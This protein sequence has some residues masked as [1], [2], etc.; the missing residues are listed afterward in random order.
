MNQSLF[1][2]APRLAVISVVGLLTI[3]PCA[4]ATTVLQNLRTVALSD[5]V[6]PGVPS[7]V[8][9]EQFGYPLVDAFGRT[10]FKGLLQQNT[11]G[12]TASTRGVFWS[13]AAI[14]DLRYVARQGNDVPGFNFKFNDIFSGDE[15]RVSPYRAKPLETLTISKT[16]AE[17][18]FL[19]L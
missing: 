4:Q 16:A 2:I 18:R 12:V 6:F 10:T 3:T 15:G 8:L 11:G 1:A 14:D 17:G 9:V 5:Q 7:G 13:E 19:R